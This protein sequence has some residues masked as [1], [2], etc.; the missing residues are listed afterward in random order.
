MFE[1][2][3]MDKPKLGDKPYKKIVPL[4]GRFL[5]K[6]KNEFKKELSRNGKQLKHNIYFMIFAIA[7]F[8]FRFKGS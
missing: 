8:D 1:D 7:S 6:L 4:K 5:A 2:A 3:K